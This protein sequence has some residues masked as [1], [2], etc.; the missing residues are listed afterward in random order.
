MKKN[1][2]F[3]RE[4]VLK[5][6]EQTAEII[7]RLKDGAYLMDLKSE[8]SKAT[9]SMFGYLYGYVY[10]EILKAQGCQVDKESID[11][12]DRILKNKYGAAEVKKVFELRRK[13]VS[14]AK[15][16]GFKN[17]PYMKET[18]EL[19]PKD[20]A[21]YTVEEMQNYWMAL[22][23]FASLFFGLVLTDPD[24]GWDDGYSETPKRTEHK[25]TVDGYHGGSSNEKREA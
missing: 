5:V 20:K 2:I 23:E 16:N 8:K 18:E 11:E 4:G 21:A 24:P 1:I 15:E 6:P 3:M 19:R 25:P 17:V 12:L 14:L 7:G 9:G 10:P 22:H 13:V